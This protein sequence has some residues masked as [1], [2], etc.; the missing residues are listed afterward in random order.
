MHE[1]S[2]KELA[3]HQYTKNTA[4]GRKDEFPMSVGSQIA[5]GDQ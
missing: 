3:A 5:I 4:R 1:C 2:L